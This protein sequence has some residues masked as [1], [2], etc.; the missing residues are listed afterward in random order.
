MKVSGSTIGF[1]PAEREALEALRRRFTPEDLAEIEKRQ[2]ESAKLIARLAATDTLEEQQRLA[3]E[4][5][6]RFDAWIRGRNRIQAT[7]ARRPRLVPVIKPRAGERQ[8]EHRPA[9]TR[10]ASSSSSTS[11]Q[12]PGDDHAEELTRRIR[13]HVASGLA[14]CGPDTLAAPRL[15][16]ALELLDRLAIRLEVDGP[17]ARIALGERP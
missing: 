3:D 4:L 15:R 7:P 12:D 8:R 17:I 10:R 6:P 1:T 9:T 2:R 5:C 16:A 11:S 13:R 14:L